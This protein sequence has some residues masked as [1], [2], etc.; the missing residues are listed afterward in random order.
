M[1]AYPS[2]DPPLRNPTTGTAGCCARAITGHASA[3]TRFFP[4]SYF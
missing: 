1:G 2:A 4:F 3:L